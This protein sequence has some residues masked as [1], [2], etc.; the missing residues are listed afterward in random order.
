MVDDEV[1]APYRSTGAP[2]WFCDGVR[3]GWAACWLKP[4]VR[5]TRLVLAHFR[6]SLQINI[7]H[8]RVYPQAGCCSSSSSTFKFQLG[9]R[10]ASS[11]FVCFSSRL[12]TS[13]ANMPRNAALLRRAWPSAAKLGARWWWY[14]LLGRWSLL[15]VVVQPRVSSLD[16][17]QREYVGSDVLPLVIVL[18][19]A[20]S[21]F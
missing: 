12:R 5:D 4:S 3:E 15:P 8:T 9:L 19:K 17:H 18:T 21:H 6:D 2:T 20:S 16:A 11:I 10:M 14:S 7:L 1:G 13:V